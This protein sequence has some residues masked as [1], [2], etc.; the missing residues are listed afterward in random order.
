[1]VSN[2]QLS[3]KAMSSN[4]R[5]GNETHSFSQSITVQQGF[6][7]AQLDQ[8]H[9]PCYA[10]IENISRHQ[11]TLK[12][13]SYTTAGLLA[14]SHPNRRTGRLG[15]DVSINPRLY[16]CRCHKMEPA[17]TLLGKT[18]ETKLGFDRVRKH[19]FISF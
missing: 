16:S 14:A 12:V 3:A 10:T 18:N 8:C 7:R 9:L 13:L 19:F 2:L 4:K 6:F 17:E 1:M 15:G 5:G 11:K